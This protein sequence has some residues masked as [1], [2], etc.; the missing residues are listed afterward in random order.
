MQGRGTKGRKARGGRKT[1]SVTKM[2]K[3][4]MAYKRESEGGVEGGT[5]GRKVEGGR[6]R[7]RGRE[8]GGEGAAM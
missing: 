4:L 5:R 3:R 7:E 2:M 1:I 8:A 6:E